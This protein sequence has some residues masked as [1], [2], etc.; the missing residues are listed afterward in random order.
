MKSRNPGSVHITLR[1]E[2]KKLIRNPKKTA[3]I[4]ETYILII[5]WSNFL[6]VCLKYSKRVLKILK[7][8]G[9][10]SHSLTWKLPD[11]V[12][13][14]LWFIYAI[15]SLVAQ[16]RLGWVVAPHDP[17]GKAGGTNARVFTV[18]T[19]LTAG[20]EVG[21]KILVPK[22]TPVPVRAGVGRSD[23]VRIIRGFIAFLCGFQIFARK[24]CVAL[25]LMQLM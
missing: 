11:S 12:S 1:D 19:V 23:F 3:R 9:S 4:I 21:R 2:K 8:F 10:S 13:S 24:L 5:L 20:R 22:I 7:G 18:S 16:G 25:L 15:S 17:V 14:A 6:K